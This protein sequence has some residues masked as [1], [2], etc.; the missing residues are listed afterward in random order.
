MEERAM[1][2]TF[3]FGSD[4]VQLRQAMRELLQ[5]S[6][7]PSG[8][9]RSPWSTGSG[10]MARPIPLDVYATPNEAV[11]IAAIPGMSPENLEITCT[12]N[13][14][15]LSG[16]LPSAA[17]SEQ[18]RTAT[19]Y[20]HELW[21]GNFQRTVTLPFEVDPAQAQAAF[22]HGSVIRTL[23]KADWAK[24]HKI[25]IKAN[26]GQQAIGAGASS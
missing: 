17:Q 21:S 2:N 14:L 15:T 1:V 11:V 4:F 20:L 24:S 7:V 3:P 12:D 26:N 5:D 23:P 10:A 13:T 16:S 6:F 25:A 18:G 22:E 9:S 19:W 8:G